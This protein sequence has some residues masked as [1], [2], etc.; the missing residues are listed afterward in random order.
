MNKYYT[1][2]KWGRAFAVSSIAVACMF[3]LSACSGAKPTEDIAAVEAAATDNSA[4]DIVNTAYK[5]FAAG[6]M[7][8]LTGVMSEDIIWNEAEGNPYADGNPYKGPNEILSGVFAR[9]GGDWTG[10][11]ATPSEFVAEGNRVIVFGRY[12]G[13]YNATGKTL[14][15]QFVHS[16]T[17]T[18]GQ[19][20]GFQQYMDTLQQVAVMSK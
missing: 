11:T 19:I 10:Y 8:M 6:D 2:K 1:N 7:D 5:G 12:A 9:I 20:T 17:V 18:K 13:T 3:G 15:A 14:D 16:W 4:A